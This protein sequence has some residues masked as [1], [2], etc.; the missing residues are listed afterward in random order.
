MILEI[1]NIFRIISILF[2]FSVLLGCSHHSGPDVPEADDST[3]ELRMD[4][5]LSDAGNLTA[6]ESQSRASRASD[7]MDIPGENLEHLRVIIVDNTDGKIVHNRGIVLNG[8]V[9]VYDDMRFVVKPSTAYNIYLLGNCRDLDGLG[10]D[11]DFGQDALPVGSVYPADK[12]ENAIIGC[13]AGDAMIVNSGQTKKA[14]PI[15]EKYTIVTDD[16][17]GEQHQIQNVSFLMFRAAVKFSFSVNVSEDFIGFQKDR[18]TAVNIS[19]LGN[20]MYLLPHDARFYNDDPESEEGIVS[21]S[22]P[23]GVER[24]NFDFTLPG[25]GLKL[26]AG[27]DEYSWS[28]LIYFPEAL[29]PTGGFLC[30]LKFENHVTAIRQVILPSLPYGLPRNTHVKVDITLGNNNSVRVTA[31]VLPWDQ[32]VSEFNFSNEVG[33]GTD[34]ALKFLE[35]TYLDLDKESGRLVLKNSVILQGSFGISTPKGARWDAYLISESGRTDAIQFILEDGSNTN[36]ISGIV[37]D[38]VDNFNIESVFPPGDEPNSAI[39]QVVVTTDD[40]RGIPINIL[41]GAGYGENVK[42]LTIIQNPL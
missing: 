40:G 31:K 36:R 37:D 11:L 35:G 23:D 8:G 18:L 13:S 24:G 14:L 26:S 9:S 30:T 16:P 22:V 2:G 17:S 33:I 25:Q 5:R 27:M 34:G 6:S 42:N 39:L 1:S 12:I 19:G 29:T 3:I 28:P 4:I 10:T 41:T 21:F 15:T 7:L 38:Y 20:S 32:M